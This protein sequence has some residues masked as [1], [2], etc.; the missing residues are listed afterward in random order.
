[1]TMRLIRLTT[2]F[3]PFAL[4]AF[5]QLDSDASRLRGMPPCT[6]IRTANCIPTALYGT[7]ILAGGCTSTVTNLSTVVLWPFQSIVTTCTSGTSEPGLPIR[8]ATIRDLRVVNKEAS[9]TA[10][11]GVVTVYKNGAGQSLTCTI[12]T[13][14]ACQDLTGSFTTASNDQVTV[15][16]KSLGGTVTVGPTWSSGGTACTNGTQTVTFSNG[17]AGVNATGT[18]AVSGGA[19][20]G[21]ATIVTGGAG[22]ASGT[23][24]TAGQVATCTGASVFTGGTAANDTLGDVQAT[25]EVF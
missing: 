21:A 15:K 7:A 23:P 20:S 16:V 22:Y 19:P 6:A 8:A 13:A 4:A 5:A 9:A 2:L 14:N 3:A 12:G 10:G 1:M 17:T 18:I 25:F 24:P 11:D